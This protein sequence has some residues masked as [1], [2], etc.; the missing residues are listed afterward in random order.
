MVYL[1]FQ[2]QI[3][4]NNLVSCASSGIQLLSVF[5]TFGQKLEVL[6]SIFCGIKI[7]LEQITPPPFLDLPP[8]CLNM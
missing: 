5:E 4:K 8:L 2:I 6:F 1:Y 7:T 3:Q